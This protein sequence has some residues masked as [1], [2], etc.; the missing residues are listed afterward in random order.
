MG[1]S[2]C[3][4]FTVLDA[5]ILIGA[6]GVALAWIRHGLRVGDVE[7]EFTF[8]D[9]SPTR[10]LASLW[11]WISAALPLPAIATPTVLGLRLRRPRPR[12]A[13]LARQPGL[14][15]C[16]AALVAMASWSV[17]AVIEWSFLDGV[18]P[19]GFG[20]RLESFLGISFWAG[21]SAWAPG[22]GVAVTAAWVVLVL[23]GR[24][25]AEPVWI[26]RL[27]RIVGGSWMVVLVASWFANAGL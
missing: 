2:S 3:R 21:S 22:P 1:D 16:I 25:R 6:T 23:G 4:R 12:R 5:L 18:Q 15:A 7:L 26:D 13:R 24:W 11:V 27:G 8:R 17:G 9:R 14:V 10:V 20:P 19:H